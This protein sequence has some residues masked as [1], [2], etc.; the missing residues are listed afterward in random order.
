MSSFFLQCDIWQ[1]FKTEVKIFNHLNQFKKYR[2]MSG[3]GT[4]PFF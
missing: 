3:S 2:T 4:P 1:C